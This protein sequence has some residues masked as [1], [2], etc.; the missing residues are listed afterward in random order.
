MLSSQVL[1]RELVPAKMKLGYWPAVAAAWG[2][3]PR[4]AAINPLNENNFTA[5]VRR[6]LRHPVDL[7]RR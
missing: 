6:R 3:I 2:L 1:A 7:L 5:P 4:S